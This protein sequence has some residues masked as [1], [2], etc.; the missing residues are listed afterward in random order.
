[1]VV[2]QKFVDFDELAHD[3]FGKCHKLGLQVRGHGE[4]ALEQSSTVSGVD[5]GA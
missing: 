1:L 3:N 5:P 4:A 2:E